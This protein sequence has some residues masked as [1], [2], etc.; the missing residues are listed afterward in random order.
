ML[1]PRREHLLMVSLGRLFARGEYK[2]ADNK[3]VHDHH[4]HQSDGVGD[5]GVKT[6]PDTQLQQSQLDRQRD[7]V[8]G[9]VSKKL[10]GLC[11][12]VCEDK[13]FVDGVANGYATDIAQC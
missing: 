6:Q 7:Q 12:G 10:V 11:G 1:Q 5:E 4:D 9:G 8:D 2:P 3:E 13:N